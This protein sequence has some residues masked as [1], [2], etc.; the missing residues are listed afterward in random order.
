MNEGHP[1][2]QPALH[3]G[4]EVEEEPGVAEEP[5]E[6]GIESIVERYMLGLCR[7]LAEMFL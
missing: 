5:V 3:Q 4:E 7:K 6:E 2:H 1:I